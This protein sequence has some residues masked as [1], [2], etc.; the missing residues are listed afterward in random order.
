MHSRGFV[1]VSE[2]T[3]ETLDAAMGPHKE[4]D[5]DNNDDKPVGHWDWYRAGGRYDGYLVSDEEMRARRR[6]NG[7]NHQPENERIDLNCCKVKDLPTDRR[8][9][10]FFVA[11]GEWVASEVY[12]E[13]AICPFYNELGSYVEV[14][15]FYDRLTS[16]LADHPDDYII[17]IDAHS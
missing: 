12:D 7:F 10:Y 16:A 17:V 9:V 13:Q 4:Q 1:I 15:D 5:D 2:P 3:E 6:D 14:L 11:D 8:S